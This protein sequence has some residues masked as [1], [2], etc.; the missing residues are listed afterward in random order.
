MHIMCSS[1]SG[2]TKSYIHFLGATKAKKSN[3]KKNQ[4]YE[5]NK[6][7]LIIDHKRTKLVK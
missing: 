2:E 1:N 7:S 5:L 6:F 4:L 3:K